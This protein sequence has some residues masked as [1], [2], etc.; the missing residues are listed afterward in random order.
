[1]LKLFFGV[2]LVSFTST[3][4]CQLEPASGTCGD[5]NITEAYVGCIGEPVEIT[6]DVCTNVVFTYYSWD[7]STA[8]ETLFQEH[9]EVRLELMVGGY[10]ARSPTA[11][12]CN[13]SE[14]ERVGFR[15]ADDVYLWEIPYQQALT[16]LVTLR[17]E[18]GCRDPNPNSPM[19]P[20]LNLRVRPNLEYWLAANEEELRIAA[21]FTLICLGFCVRLWCGEACGPPGG[22]GAEVVDVHD[23]NNW[24]AE[25]RKK[26]KKKKSGRNS[27]RRRRHSSSSSSSSS[28]DSSSSSRVSSSNPGPLE[29]K[30]PPVPSAPPSTTSLPR[31]SKVVDGNNTQSNTVN[32]PPAYEDALREPGAGVKE[33][34]EKAELV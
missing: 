13:D 31:Y 4:A 15:E 18:R 2:I 27:R 19:Y 25:A 12:N 24:T 7:I 1:M 8:V 33:V 16:G 14:L 9:G 30:S 17:F 6:P 20:E 23:S 34:D 3:N 32:P 11:V 21:V 5:A 29:G 22:V 10:F 28:S 26:K